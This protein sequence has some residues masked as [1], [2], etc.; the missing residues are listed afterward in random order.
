MKQYEIKDV[1]KTYS[2]FLP[3]STYPWVMLS[4]ASCAVFFAWF[5]GTYLFPGLPMI[6]RMIC[7]WSNP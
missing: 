1:V 2:R 5:G 3:I 4:I 6:Q 7:Q